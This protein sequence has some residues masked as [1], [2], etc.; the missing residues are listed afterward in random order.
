MK[1]LRTL[2]NLGIGIAVLAGIVAVLLNNKAKSDAKAAKSQETEK[3]VSV[4]V[5]T[6]GKTT[7]SR[8]LS[9]I[10]TITANNDVAIVSET[11]GRVVAIGAK[12]G[13]YKPAGS[14][15]AQVDDELKL[16]NFKSAEVA[17]EKAKKDLE[18]YEALLKEGGISDAQVESARLNFKSAEAQYI[19]ARRQL[20]DTRITTPIS[21]IVTERRVDIGSVVSNGM[22]VANVVDIAKLKVKV[23]VAEKDVFK[24]KAG[25]E[26][27]VTTDVYPN[28]KFKGVIA[29]ISAKG[30]EAHTYPVEITLNN[31]KEYPLK[32]GMFGRVHFTSLGERQTLAIPREALL[33]SVRS[34][35][36]FVAENGVARLRPITVGQEVGKMLE[37]LEGLQE[38]ELVIVSGQNNL[39]DGYAINVINN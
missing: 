30:D 32:A 12:V 13:D 16:A 27:E 34:A 21:G 35:R 39:R 3:A 2:R 10:G 4:S 28:V 20:Q 38:G 9:L 1:T 15:I 23:N 37:V 33:G 18:R 24:L 5:V 25:E 6:V 29:S 8:T 11:S 22:V 17:Y 7:L 26:V 36:V 14:V 31:S 19:V